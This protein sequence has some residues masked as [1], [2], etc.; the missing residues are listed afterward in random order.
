MLTDILFQ[1]ERGRPGLPGEKGEAGD[2]VSRKYV[3]P[4]MKD[5]QSEAESY[6]ILN[7]FNVYS[8]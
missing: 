2:P 1:G 4:W 7:Y 5:T 6:V 3:W 8:E